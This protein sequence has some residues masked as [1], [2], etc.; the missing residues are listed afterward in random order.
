MGFPS[1][2]REAVYRNQMS[3][4]VRFLD[5]RHG[6][7]YKV[8][9]LC[10]ERSYDPKFFHNRVATFPFDDHNAPPIEIIEKFCLDAD[11]WL[12]Q[13]SRNIVVTHCKA[14]KGR[15]GVM[16][17]AYLLYSKA[18]SN[19]DEAFRFYA[20]ART[21]NAK[22]VTIPSQRR[23]V[24][25][26]GELLARNL[27]YSPKSLHFRKMTMTSLPKIGNNFYFTISTHHNELYKSPITKIDRKESTFVMTAETGEF[28][29]K[30]DIK[31][32]VFALQGVNEKPK[33]ILHTWFNTFFIGLPI[34]ENEGVAQNGN[35]DAGNGSEIS[36]KEKLVLTLNR[37]VIEGAYKDK[38]RKIWNTDFSLILEFSEPA[39]S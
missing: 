10:S 29:I 3:D 38:G 37:H 6:E 20:E 12:K 2:G 15:T 19:T 35:H 31:I 24:R 34:N 30:G 11:E 39:I 32:A 18:F 7:N 36:N 8:Y 26:Y 16:I 25:Y 9:N 13:D 22:G 5:S 23:Y 28:F 21:H 14:G 17:C 33:K 4:V 1:Q 27:P